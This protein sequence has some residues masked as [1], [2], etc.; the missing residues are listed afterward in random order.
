[1]LGIYPA[2]ILDGLAYGVSLLLYSQILLTY[3]AKLVMQIDRF[4]QQIALIPH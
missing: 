2:A 1:M 4:V 3:L